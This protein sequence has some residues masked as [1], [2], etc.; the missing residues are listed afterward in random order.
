MRVE[1]N[2][3]GRTR[4]CAGFSLLELVI[5]AALIFVLF[6][7]YWSRGSASYQRKQKAVCQRNL[8]TVY[9]SLQSYANDHDGKHPSIVGAKTS[10]WP[11]S[12]LVPQY[13]VRTEL[14]ICPGSK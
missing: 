10:E 7:V 12:L 9:L 5:V 4:V 14:F 2:P 1:A 3:S 6:T 11:L 13:T 8:Q